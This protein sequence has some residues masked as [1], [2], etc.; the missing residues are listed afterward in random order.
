MQRN[1][2]AAELH[3][4]AVICGQKLLVAAHAI[5]DQEDGWHCVTGEPFQSKHAS[6][7]HGLQ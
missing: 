4:H 2:A 5:S 7:N 3:N 1:V 6:F